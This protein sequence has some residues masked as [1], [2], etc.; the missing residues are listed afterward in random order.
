M[1]YGELPESTG[2]STYLSIANVY[3]SI[4][5]TF[6]KAEFYFCSVEMASE[7]FLCKFLRSEKLNDLFWIEGYRWPC[8]LLFTDA[9]TCGEYTFDDMSLYFG[10]E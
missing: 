7:F 9:K 8:E 5:F 3:M 2:I 4:F 6:L 10:Y 1:D